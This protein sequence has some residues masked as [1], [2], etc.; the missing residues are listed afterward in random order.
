MA[1][2]ALPPVEKLPLAQRKDVRDNFD[3]KKADMEKELSSA[4]GQAWTIDVN[5]NA[6]YPYAP[7][8]NYGQ[9][10]PGSMTAEYIDSAIRRIK[11]YKDK[12][13]A[14]GVDELNKA[15][16]AHVLT[17][18]M[19]L[20]E[21]FTYCGPKISDDGKLVI[22][23]NPNNVACNID[24]AIN[25][26]KLTAALN[27]APGA[28]S[29]A[30]SFVARQGIAQDYDTQ[31]GEVKETLKKQL[32]KDITLEPNFEEAFAKL[33]ANGLATEYE[34]RLGSFVYLYFK[35]VARALEYNNVSKDEMVLEAL[36]EEM[37]ENKIAF[38]LLDKGGLSSGYG[39]A[40]FEGGVVYVQTD[41]DHYGSNID[42]AA[43]KILDQL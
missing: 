5:I 36:E 10:S 22:L 37:G 16:T 43:N 7:N 25:N 17:I 2:T 8:D 30:L 12:F 20:E 27:E 11:Y 39:E 38:R 32:G 6:I 21:K 19:D 13:G 35:S 24:D 9:H 14:D 28:S 26:D 31:I 29:A 18:D 1:V 40:K 42:D 41:I 15:A 3:N 4:L 33:K 34:S 23:I